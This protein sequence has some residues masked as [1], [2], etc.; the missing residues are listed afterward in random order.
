MCIYIYIVYV[1]IYIY[2]CVNIHYIYI[3]IYASIFTDEALVKPLGL[4]VGDWG[5]TCVDLGGVYLSIV[6]DIIPCNAQ[7]QQCSVYR[8]KHSL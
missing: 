8:F 4:S 7:T 1:H 6:I 3:Y 5:G 2:I